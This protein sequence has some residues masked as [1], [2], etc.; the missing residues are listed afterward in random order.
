[1]SQKRPIAKRYDLNEYEAKLLKE[2]AKQ[3]GMK[4]GQLVRELITGY[5]PTEKPGKDFFEA[6]NDINKI[7]VNINQIAAIANTNGYIDEAFFRQCVEDLNNK[8][9]EIK[10]IVLKAKPYPISYYEKLL[11]E[12][13]KAR[14]EG[15]PEPKFGDDLFPDD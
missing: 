4:E 14:A 13:K 12:Q 6:M 7:G 15:R 3:A 2:K 11:L 8:M 5:A 9:L 1:M 10:N